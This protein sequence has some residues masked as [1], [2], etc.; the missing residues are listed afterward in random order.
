MNR[1]KLEEE[2]EKERGRMLEEEAVKER[3]RMLEEEVVKEMLEVEAVKE[4]ERMLEAEAVKE[5]ERM[6]EAEA[7]ILPHLSFRINQKEYNQRRDVPNLEKISLIVKV[8]TIDPYLPYLPHLPHLPHHSH[9]HQRLHMFHIRIWTKN[10]E[11]H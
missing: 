2:V 10:S 7:V 3:G 8:R 5:R 4:R 1:K 6:L 11:M 9:I